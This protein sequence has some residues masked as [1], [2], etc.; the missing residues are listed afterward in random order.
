MLFFHFFLFILHLCSNLKH[1]ELLSD[2]NVS[3]SC[4]VSGYPFECGKLELGSYVV[5][6]VIN[7]FRPEHSPKAGSN[8]YQWRNKEYYSARGDFQIGEVLT[9]PMLKG[10]VTQHSFSAKHYMMYIGDDYVFHA[11]TSGTLKSKLIRYEAPFYNLKILSTYQTG[12]YVE[13]NT[14]AQYVVRESVYS[15]VTESLFSK[16]VQEKKKT[17]QS[18]IET[19]KIVKD[20]VEPYINKKICYNLRYCNCEHWVRYIQFNK[21]ATISTMTNE[22]P[23]ERCFT[24]C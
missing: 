3:E 19:Q 12:Y 15:K 2:S 4:R 11:T 16:N 20:L 23:D 22:Y 7:Y 17:I 18:I 13:T 14:C 5:R 10:V 9:C 8:V 1:V 21:T 24:V 6:H